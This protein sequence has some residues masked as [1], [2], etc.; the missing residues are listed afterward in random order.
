MIDIQKSY[1]NYK[2]EVETNPKIS[3]GLNIMLSC[4]GALQY[5]LI[6][7]IANTNDNGIKLETLCKFGFDKEVISIILQELLKGKLIDYNKEQ[8]IFTITENG[9]NILLALNFKAIENLNI[10]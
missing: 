3:A 5:A 6:Q 8:G 1:A 9:K 10:K 2:K 4:E 7:C